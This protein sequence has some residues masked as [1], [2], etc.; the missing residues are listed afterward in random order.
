MEKVV[1]KWNAFRAICTAKASLGVS[2][3][4]LSVLDALLS[5]HPE[6]ALSGDGLV[7]FPS[8]RQLSLRAHGM[9][10]A[11]L[12]RH[13]GVLV[14]AGLI[15]RRDSPNGKRYARKRADGDVEVAFGFD[16][17]PIVARADE[18]EALAEKVR[19][20]ERALRFVRERITICR[21]DVTKGIEAC[22]GEGVTAPGGG[23][24]V[25]A[26]A[27]V[28]ALFRSIVADI[29]RVGV[30]SELEPVAT[31]LEA[32]AA[33][34]VSRLER[35]AKI[36]NQSAS[37]SQTERHI[38]NSKPENL[39]ESEP[40]LPKGPGAGE[41]RAGEASVPP[42]ASYPLGMVLSAC[43]DIIDYCKGGITSWRDFRATVAVVR[44]MLGISL[45]A[46][47]EAELVMGDLQ[48]AI[49]V[50]AILQKGTA[51]SSAGGYLRD[52][53]RRAEHKSFTLGPMLMALIS[54][55][56]RRVDRT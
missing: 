26:W 24:G 35:H 53:T 1:H 54:T 42:S 47:D 48:A 5:F 49:V 8:N 11:T 14:L 10:A 33:D 52:L 55:R 50:A 56:H 34:V 44:P 6:T 29:P 16:L 20:E 13:L 17:G 25:A 51:V 46:W 3:R 7:V 31:A 27:P 39:T 23:D 28:I 18:F 22:V 37:E 43:P 32:M 45:T 40:S 19:L 9:A 2:E 30:L 41:A 36:S 15:L 21:R 12:R 38:Q 4:A